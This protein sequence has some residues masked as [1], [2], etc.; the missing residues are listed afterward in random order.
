M[1]M[2]NVKIDDV[3]KLSKL[4]NRTWFQ[5]LTYLLWFS[6][7]SQRL[8]LILFIDLCIRDYHTGYRTFVILNKLTDLGFILPVSNCQLKYSDNNFSIPIYLAVGLIAQIIY[9]LKIRFYSA[10]ELPSCLDLGNNKSS[11][12]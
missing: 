8:L 6:V 3:K 11:R 9:F 10:H 4:N 12:D 2:V 1:K 5:K 7:S